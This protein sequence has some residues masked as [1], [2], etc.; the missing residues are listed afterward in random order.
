MEETFK[1]E[2]RMRE[3]EKERQKADQPNQNMWV[4]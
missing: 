2:C 3:R 4:A 1:D